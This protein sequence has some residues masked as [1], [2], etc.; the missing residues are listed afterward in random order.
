M[1][2]DIEIGEKDLPLWVAK[3]RRAIKEA[4]QA[5]AAEHWRAGRPVYIWRDEQV[6]ALY[7]DGT[8]IPAEEAKRREGR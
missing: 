8:C 7:G 2:E 6:M 5:A 1:T 4:A 3:A